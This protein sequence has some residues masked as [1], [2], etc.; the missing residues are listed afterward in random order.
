MCVLS[1][2]NT[3]F[4]LWLQYVGIDEEIKYQAKGLSANPRNTKDPQRTAGWA[5]WLAGLASRAK[6]SQVEKLN[7]L[8]QRKTQFLRVRPK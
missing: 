4:H 2:L 8:Q 3:P 5:R 6:I 7:L 1:S